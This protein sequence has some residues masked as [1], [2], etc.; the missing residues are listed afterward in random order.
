MMT[1]TMMM[2][3]M[4]MMMNQPCDCYHSCHVTACF[5]LY[6]IDDEAANV[7]AVVAANIDI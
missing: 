1:M 2:M 3:M 5:D 4:M 6:F 7:V